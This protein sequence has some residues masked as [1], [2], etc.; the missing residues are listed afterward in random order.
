MFEIADSSG[1][2][3]STDE[4]LVFMDFPVSRHFV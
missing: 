3:G 2:S 1:T 4:D